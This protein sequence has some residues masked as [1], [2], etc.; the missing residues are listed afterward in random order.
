MKLKLIFSALAL[1]VLGLANADQPSS[2]E[3]NLTDI[4]LPV[5]ESG[6]IT[7]RA[8][9]DCPFQQA[10]AIDG[11]TWILNTTQTSYAELREGAAR[12]TNPG[13]SLVTLTYDKSE[14]RITALKVTVR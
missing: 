2:F 11:A 8:C 14:N 3:L 6:T 1:T 7:F 10:R 4:R 5:S 9:D 12:A 13:R